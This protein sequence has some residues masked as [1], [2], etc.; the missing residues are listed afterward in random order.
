VP[1][2]ETPDDEQ[3]SEGAETHE[4]DGFAAD[5]VDERDGAPVAGDGTSADEDAGTGGEIV[6]DV[7]DGRATAVSDGAEHGG[8]VQVKAIKRDIEHEP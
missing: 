5:G 1:E 4:L 8:G 3:D 2:V 7:V 6:Q